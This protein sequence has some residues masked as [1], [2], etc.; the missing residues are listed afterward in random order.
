MVGTLAEQDR[1]IY[2][3]YDADFMDAG[4][5]LSPFKLPLRLGLIEHTDHAFG[6]LPGLFDDSLPDGWGLLLMDRHFRRRGF[7]PA[8]LSA[9]D[10]LAFLSDRT[11]G[12]LTYHPPAHEPRDAD[13]GLLDLFKLGRNAEDVLEGDAAE[14]LPELLRAGGSPGGARPKALAGVQGEQMICGASDLPDPFL[15]RGGEH[16]MIK[17]SARADAG[18][19]GPV[20]YAYSLMARAAGLDMPPTRLFEVR[21]GRW[22][23]RYFGVKRFDRAEGNRR[24]HMH[25]FANLIH[26]NFRV[27]STDYADLFKATRA[28][29][30]NHRDMLR[31]FGMMAFN[32]AAHNR[33][34]HAKNFAFVLDDETGG[35]SL[36]PAYDLI[37][38]SGPGGE[39]TMTLLGEGRR[40]TGEHCLQ[41]ADQFGIKPRESAAIME[42]VNSAVGRWAAFADQAGCSRRVTADIGAGLMRV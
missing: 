24:K 10:R 3:E 13:D 9:L 7:D 33:D 15:G 25:T 34:D 29:T 6:P 16:W 37:H 1:R 8:S 26:A 18:D 2:F 4:L 32:V 23:R 30:R 35:W 5:E 42:Q 20:E 17:F 19:A 12:A 40:P 38:T 41:L 11:M 27:P 14:V 36:A 39:H 28:L 31:L 22:V 21:R